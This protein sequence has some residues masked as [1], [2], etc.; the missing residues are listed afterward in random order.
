[1]SRK[2]RFIVG[3]TARWGRG[4]LWLIEVDLEQGGEFVDALGE[5]LE[6]RLDGGG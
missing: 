6:C 3:A 5:K 1:M 4:G 2:A